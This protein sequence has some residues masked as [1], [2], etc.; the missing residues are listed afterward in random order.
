MRKFALVLFLIAAGLAAGPASAITNY[1]PQGGPG[2]SPFVDRCP[3][4]SY[5]VGFRFLS[6]DWIDGIQPFCATFDARAGQFGMFGEASVPDTGLGFHGGSTGAMSAMSCPKDAYLMSIKFGQS[7][8]RICRFRAV[9]M[10]SDNRRVR[11]RLLPSRRRWA[12][13]GKNEFR[14]GRFLALPSTFRRTSLAR[15]ARQRSE[16]EDGLAATLMPSA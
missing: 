4:P 2:G 3:A 8:D 5:L 13:T 9:R 7:N 6:G 15:P 10:Q 14:L 16:Y 12:A 1:E 11:G